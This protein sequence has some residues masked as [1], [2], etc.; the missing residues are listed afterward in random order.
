MTVVYNVITDASGR[1]VP[2]VQVIVT[3][4][5][6]GSSRVLDLVE[7]CAVVA[8]METRTDNNGLWQLPLTPSSH[9]AAGARYR[10]RE[11]LDNGHS[12]YSIRVPDEGRHWIGELATI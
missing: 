3:V 5:P 9:F 10:V 7:K 4:G 12:D 11:V 8:Y 1:P 2:G 6:V